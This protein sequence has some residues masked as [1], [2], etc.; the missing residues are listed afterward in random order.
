MQSKPQGR[1]VYRYSP[2]IKM[3]EKSPPEGESFLVN[4]SIIKAGGGYGRAGSARNYFK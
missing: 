4:N 1:F 3:K 2:S